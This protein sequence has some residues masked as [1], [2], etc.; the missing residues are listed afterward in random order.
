M[1]IKKVAFTCYPVTDMVRSREFFEKTLGLRPGDN[2][3]DE[4]QEYDFG[5]TTFAISTMISQWIKPGSQSSVTFEVDNLKVTVETL[6][7]RKVLF[8][9]EIIETPV[10]TIAFIRDPDGNGIS[11]HQVK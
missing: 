7:Q 6:K 9:Q 2:F 3:R 8:P 10:C 1:E 4:W 5:G 11:L